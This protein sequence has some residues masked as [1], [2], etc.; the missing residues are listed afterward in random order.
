MRLEKNAQ[1]TQNGGRSCRFRKTSRDW[2]ATGWENNKQTKLTM[3][4]SPKTKELRPIGVQLNQR[5]WRAVRLLKT[6]SHF[7]HFAVHICDLP[8]EFDAKGESTLTARLHDTL[9][10]PL[11]TDMRILNWKNKDG[12]TC[13][14]FDKFNTQFWKLLRQGHLN[15]KV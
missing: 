15:Y 11:I 8:Q 7:V 2:F 10:V 3:E 9:S 14:S 5:F 1:K 4:P 12:H 13:L 6:D